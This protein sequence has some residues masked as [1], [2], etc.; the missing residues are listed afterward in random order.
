MRCFAPSDSS[1][2]GIS[3]CDSRIEVCA[4]NRTEGEDQS[5]ERSSGG[6]GIGQKSECGIA[7]GE[8]LGHDAGADDCGEEKCGT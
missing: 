6:D 1:L 8:I 3:K 2:Q 4:G 5:D 7:S